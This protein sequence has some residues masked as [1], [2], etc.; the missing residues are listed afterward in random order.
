MKREKRN[1]ETECSK[2]NNKCI[3][4]SGREIDWHRT[5]ITLGEENASYK[6]NSRIIAVGTEFLDLF[7]VKLLTG[8]NFDP[9]IESDKKAMLISEEASRM[10]G[11]SSYDDAL[12]KLIFI[13][14]RRFEVIGVVRNYHYRTL[15]TRIEPVLYMQSYPRGPAFAVKVASGE[16]EETISQLKS[17]WEEAYAGNVFRYFF[18]DEFFDRQYHS[19]RQVGNVVT[20]L[21]NIGSGHRLLRFV[22]LIA[23]FG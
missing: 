3:Q 12:G 1:V 20:T 11:F 18:L 4:L 8:R 10:F 13:G 16:M 7:G 5:D 19:E 22:C 15:Q 6:Y 9:A 21:G 14:N 23:V 2:G 17:K